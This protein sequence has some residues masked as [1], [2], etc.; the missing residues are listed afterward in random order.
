MD[1]GVDLR[2]E[3]QSV[4]A[5]SSGSFES[6]LGD[7]SFPYPQQLAAIARVSGVIHTSD[8]GIIRTS[9]II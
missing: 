7:L 4:R 5:I 3:G 2:W 9:L 1:S 8:L 6:A